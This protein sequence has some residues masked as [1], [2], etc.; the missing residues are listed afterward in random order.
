MIYRRWENHH[1][2]YV[3]IEATQLVGCKY[4]LQYTCAFPNPQQQASFLR[5]QPGQTGK[6][7]TWVVGNTSYCLGIA[8]LIEYW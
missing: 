6:V 5:D 8:K 3:K 4:G 2:F 7:Q 1:K